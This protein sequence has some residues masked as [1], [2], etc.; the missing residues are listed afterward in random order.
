MDV[1]LARRFA[2]AV[3]MYLSTIHFL[4]N[5]NI[6]C[7]NSVSYF[8]DVNLLVFVFGNLVWRGKGEGC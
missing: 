7:G 8:P 4:R 5:R 1:A 6:D 2:L 3:C